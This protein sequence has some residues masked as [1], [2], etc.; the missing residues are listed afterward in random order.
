MRC[1]SVFHS[2]AQALTRHQT[3]LRVKNA[4]QD[5]TQP[6]LERTLPRDDW[7]RAVVN[8]AD[9]HSPRW[10]HLLVIG[11]LLLGFGP[12][13]DD[14]LSRNMRA[15]LEV[16][17]MKAVNASLVDLAE[18]DDLGEQTVTVVLNHTFPTLSDQV[19][20]RVDY[21]LLL[22]VLL[23]ATLH[24]SE[25]LR[26]AYFL[27][28]VDMDVQPISETQFCWPENSQS[29]QTV[30][31]I[32][33]SPIVS[34]L[35][36]L[37]R[38]TGHAVEQATQPYLVTAALEDIEGF[39]RTVYLQ[40]RQTKLSEIDASEEHVHLNN[41]SLTKTLQTLWKVLRSILFAT[42]IILRSAIGRLLGD[43]G[44]ANHDGG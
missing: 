39:A 33:S 25:G 1:L 28:A 15:T 18:L 31:A 23:R 14:H 22:P 11:G 3:A 17:L 20:T 4:A 16:A 26:S 42:V 40:W 21:N 13:E 41:E 32:S 24:S 44:L 12:V 30:Q 29:F 38:L 7:I 27:G 34:S 10:R 19:R 36:P 9:E 43:A 6:Q 35:G 8:G 37:A 5:S 2:A